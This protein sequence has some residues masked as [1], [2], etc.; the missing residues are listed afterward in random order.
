MER[1]LVWYDLNQRQPERQSHHNGRIAVSASWLC[2]FAMLLFGPAASLWAQY[3][4]ITKEVAQE[5]Q[6][7]RQAADARS[8][9]AWERAQPEIAAWAAK[10]K[11]YIPDAARPGDLPSAD[12]PAFPGAQG[13]GMYSF[14]GRGGRVMV[15]SNLDDRGPGSFREA[16]E[17]GGPRTVVFNVAGIIRLQERIRIR[18]PILRSMAVTRPAMVS[19]S[20]GIPSKLIPTMSSSAT[21]VFAAER[22]GSATGMTRSAATRSATS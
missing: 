2:G 1:F 16:C 3:P 17:A 5:S 19:A 12:I 8:D 10:G 9:A 20:P 14:G 7:R 13:G 22:P 21:C 11:P 15:V 4:K 18:A 6:A